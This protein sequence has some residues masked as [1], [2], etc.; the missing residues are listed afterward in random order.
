MK[1]LISDP[2]DTQE[3]F[4]RLFTEFCSSIR[5]DVIS[6]WNFL[7]V[8]EQ[9]K[10]KTVNDFYCGLRFLVALGDQAEASLKICEGFLTEDVSKVVSLGHGGYSVGDLGTL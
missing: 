10:L 7:S 6:N 8:L 5:P 1:Y 4:S 3:K 9:Q 2:C